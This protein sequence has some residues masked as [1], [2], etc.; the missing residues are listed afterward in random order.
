M[1]VV[2]EEKDHVLVKTRNT[3]KGDVR[4]LIKT[5]NC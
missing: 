3:T 1:K 2:L 4:N 5:M